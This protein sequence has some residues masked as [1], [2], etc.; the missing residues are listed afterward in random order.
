MPTL[1]SMVNETGNGNRILEMCK[2]QI[3]FRLVY[4]GT[5]MSERVTDFAQFYTRVRNV[6]DYVWCSGNHKPEVDIQF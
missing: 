5:I 2:F 3:L 6:M 4:C 1:Y